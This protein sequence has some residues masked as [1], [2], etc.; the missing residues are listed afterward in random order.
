[1]FC[2]ILKDCVFKEVIYVVFLV[3]LWFFLCFLVVFLL[4]LYFLF[5][6]E[7]VCILWFNIR[8]IWFIGGYVW[9]C[10]FYLLNC[11]I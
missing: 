7:L 3:L 8:M 9:D 2:Y 6:E 11:F 5:M 4:G 10:F 1:M